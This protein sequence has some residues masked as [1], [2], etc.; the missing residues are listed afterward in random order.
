MLLFYLALIDDEND[1]QRFTRLY[2][3]HKDAMYYYA[4]KLM[5]DSALAEDAVQEAFI[6][7]AR[8]IRKTEF[9]ART[10]GLMLTVTRNTALTILKKRG[11]EFVTDIPERYAVESAVTE[12]AD[13]IV[14][15]EKRETVRMI[16]KIL[17]EMPDKYSEVFKLKYGH[18]LTYS[19]IAPLL[20][21]S[22]D[23][24]K[25]R[26]QR[27]RNIIKERLEDISHE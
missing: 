16:S 25:K 13:M 9:G 8:N 6:R 20:G 11:R 2:G 15:I 7:I 14:N 3:E 26:G 22:V 19:Q 23:A 1:R 27:A 24:A 17:D 12:N 4:L 18:S 21:I 5:K 10:R